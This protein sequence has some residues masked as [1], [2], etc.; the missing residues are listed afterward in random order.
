MTLTVLAAAAIFMTVVFAALFFYQSTH[1]ERFTQRGAL[2]RRIGVS[3][4]ALAAPVYRP[5]TQ[6]AIPSLLRGIAPVEKFAAFI[7]QSGLPLDLEQFSMV[8]AGS[9]ALGTFAAHRWL[10][11]DLSLIVGVA[12][13]FVPVAYASF[14]RG[15]LLRR[16]ANQLPYLL[17]LLRSALESG[18]TL[19]RALQIAAPDLPQ[20]MATEI[21]LVIEQVEVGASVPDALEAMYRRQ[22]DEGLG[23]LAVAVR[24]QTQVGTSLAEVLQHVSESVRSRQRLTQ[25]IRALTAQTRLSAMIVSLLPVLILVF[26]SATRPQYVAPLF[27]DPTGIRLLKIAV[28]LNASAFLIM[29]RLANIKF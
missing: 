21:G 29:R 20:P 5:R 6:R 7:H 17:D 16:F 18:H 15:R 13:G 14:A 19:L 24:L 2:V 8:M 9:F 3:S 28:V 22:P 26:F 23:F 10:P 11:W 27:N 1:E 12:A 25:Q 4:A